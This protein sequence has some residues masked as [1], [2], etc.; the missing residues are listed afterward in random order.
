MLHKPPYSC[1]FNLL[2]GTMAVVSSSRNWMIAWVS[3]NKYNNL[4]INIIYTNTYLLRRNESQESRMNALFALKRLN[5]YTGV[6]VIFSAD[7]Y[8]NSCK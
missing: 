5:G 1:S 3:G 2:I 6:A 8:N 4:Y 7:Q